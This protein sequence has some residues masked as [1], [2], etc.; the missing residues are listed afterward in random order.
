VPAVETITDPDDERIADARTLTDVDPRTK[1][2]PPCGLPGTG[3]DRHR[4]TCGGVAFGG[5]CTTVGRMEGPVWASSDIDGAVPN[6][7]RM[8]DVFL[9]GTHNFAADREMAAQVT[10]RWPETPRVARANRAFLRRVVRYLCAA[11]VRQFLDLGSGIPT[12]GNVHEI[13]EAYRP[14]SRVVYVDVDAVA[15]AH[16]RALLAGNP[17]AAVVHGDLCEP[18]RILSDDAVQRLLDFTEP[19]AVLLASVLHFIPDGREP[20]AAVRALTGATA[21]GSWL[22]VSHASE[23][24][25]DEEIAEQVAELYAT[26]TRTAGVLR[27]PAEILA[28]FDGYDLI[29]PGLV[30]LPQWRP[31][32]PDRPEDPDEHYDLTVVLASLGRRSR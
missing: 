14:D 28:F 4:W 22:A 1:W 21:A 6:V 12:A 23:P 7:A 27:S 29:E 17:H 20:Y 3:C 10:A 5:G 25:A 16:S 18:D 11:G 31:N 24:R 2:E 30:D 9:G 19:M 26:R 15:V 32:G 8:Y 13:A